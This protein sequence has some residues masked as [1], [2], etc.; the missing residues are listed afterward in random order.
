MKSIV[1][2]GG[3][4]GSIFAAGLAQAGEDVV[5]LD[6]AAGLV[7]S[8]N[9][10]GVSL[11]TSEGK[12]VT[13][14]SATTDPSCLGTA[15][16][17]LVFVKAH[18]TAAVGTALENHVG[19]GTVVATLQNGW[20]NADTLA[21]SVAAEH[22]VMGVTYHSGTVISPASVAHT[23][24]GPTFVGP[25]VAEGDPTL[26]GNVASTLMSAGFEATAAPD[27]RTEESGTNWSS[28]RPPCRSRPRRGCGRP[29]CWS[30]RR[31]P[32]WWK[33]WRARR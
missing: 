17:V 10:R 2:G 11:E 16:L 12:V 33:P 31:S 28:T 22:L 24:R 9:A 21:E 1:V 32:P 14:L 19:Q 8:I 7:D 5:V 6:S 15:D 23:G 30:C 25:Y 13:R 18:H 20:G 27:V 26:A 3:A 29:R 4:M